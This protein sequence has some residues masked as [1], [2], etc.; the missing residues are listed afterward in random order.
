M[1]EYIEE[2]FTENE[3]KKYYKNKDTKFIKEKGLLVNGKKEG[4]WIEG[5]FNDDNIYFYKD[6]NYIDNIKE[7]KSK[8][9]YYD[10]KIRIESC[11]HND[12]LEGDYTSFFFQW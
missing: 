5:Y 8:E 7:G 4:N 1:S 12:L 9:Y 6:I 10:G 2:Y 11:Y 3:L